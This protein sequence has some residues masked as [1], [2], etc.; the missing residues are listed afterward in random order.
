MNEEPLVY[1]RKP[2]LADRQALLDAFARSQDLHR[3]WTFPPDDIDVYISQAYRYLVI[4]RESQAI[5]GSFNISQIVR[6][7]FHS[8][9]LGYEAFTPHQGKGYMSK[10]MAL[11]LEEAFVKLNL[12]RL[13]ANI[14][15]GNTASITLVSKAGF[16][17]EGYSP[18]YL[19]IGGKEW[20]DH[21]RWAIINDKWSDSFDD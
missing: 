17:K 18:K 4:H 6:R 2:E 8:A 19:R 9:Y 21:E 15:P 16:N 10:G 14:Q 7:W 20:M 3:P 12:H 11:L 5:V 1:L 13:E